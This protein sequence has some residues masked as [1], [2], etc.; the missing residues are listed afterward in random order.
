MKTPS[1]DTLKQA[2]DISRPIITFAV[3]RAASGDTVYLGGSD[4]KVYSAD[5][6][7]AKF[8]LKELVTHSSY[9][10]GVALAG[11][12]LVSGGYDG[13]L[14]WYNVARNENLHTLDAHE[15]DSQGDRLAGRDAR[16]QRRRR[17]GL[18]ALGRRDRQARTR[19]AR[20]QGTDAQ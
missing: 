3:A 17:H 7:A 16:R 12:N 13:K 1:P 8:E 5:L 15:V 18:P 11:T 9:V 19:T 14:T 20:P 6:A 10:T 4:F 2:K